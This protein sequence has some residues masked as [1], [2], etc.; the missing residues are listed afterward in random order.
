MSGPVLSFVEGVASGDREDVLV[1]VDKHYPGLLQTGRVT[2]SSLRENRQRRA[3]GMSR[4]VA[5]TVLEGYNRNVPSAYTALSADPNEW[6]S[7]PEYIQGHSAVAGAAKPMP[8]PPESGRQLVFGIWDSIE[9]MDIA[10]DRY[11]V[12][13]WEMAWWKFRHPNAAYNIVLNLACMTLAMDNDR[14]EYPLRFMLSGGWESRLVNTNFDLRDSRSQ[15]VA[16]LLLRYIVDTDDLRYAAPGRVGDQGFIPLLVY[17]M[18]H[19]AWNLETED[20]HTFKY[21]RHYETFKL[22]S[23]LGML[24]DWGEY[25]NRKRLTY[26]ELRN[27]MAHLSSSRSKQTDER[28]TM[29]LVRATA[30]PDSKTEHYLLRKRLDDD[31][32]EAAR[33]V[34]ESSRG[35]VP[36]CITWDERTEPNSLTTVPATGRRLACDYYGHGSDVDRL[37]LERYDAR[38]D[39]NYSDTHLLV[40]RARQETD[41]G[42]G[43]PRGRFVDMLP[44]DAASRREFRGLEDFD[45]RM[46]GMYGPRSQRAPPGSFLKLRM[47]VEKWRNAQGSYL[48][49]AG[50]GE[51]AATFDGPA[52][53]LQFLQ[54]AFLHREQ[55]PEIVRLPAWYSDSRSPS[56]FR[57]GGGGDAA[58]IAGAS[59][60]AAPYR[61]MTGVWAALVLAFAAVVPRRA[62]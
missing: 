24:V 38:N 44:A 43:Y 22:V 52:S 31:D 62:A 16:V 53:P 35:L 42:A 12:S 48:R 57:G 56:P 46:F 17:K 58:I 18:A 15:L 33:R 34:D 5:K 13:P 7:H 6:P 60:P 4:D 8:F 54:A 28:W 40:E 1:L 2:W 37:P 9:R 61:V 55:P 41:G 59:P 19:R 45:A 50:D 25:T 39:T 51:A 36:V 47:A 26:F 27:A 32:A 20:M 30:Q 14:C 49:G 11:I 10:A 3:G 29:L 21:N 23:H